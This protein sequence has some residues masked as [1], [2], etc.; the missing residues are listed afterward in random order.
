[1]ENTEDF[2]LLAFDSVG[3]DIGSSSD[4]QLAGTLAAPWAADLGM[5]D[6]RVDAHEDLFG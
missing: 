1:M 3:D 4:E 5:I 6:K 2:N